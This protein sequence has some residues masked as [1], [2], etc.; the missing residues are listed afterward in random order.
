MKRIYQKGLRHF[1]NVFNFALL[2]SCGV[3]LSCGSFAVSKSC[4]V[5]EDYFGISPDTQ[6]NKETLD[7]LDDFNAVWLRATL[8]WSNIEPEEGK[9]Y[10]DHWDNYIAQAEAAKKKVVFVLAYDNPWL[11]SDHKEHRDMTDREIPYF[12]KYVEQV[13]SRYRTRAVYEIWNEPNWIFWYGSDKHFFALSAAT[14]KKIRE[15]EPGAVI[16]AGSTSRVSKSFTRGMFKSGAMEHTDGFSVH[17]YATSP[18]GEVM[19]IDKL[20]KIL[21]EFD[22][23]KPIWITETGYT[24]GPIGFCTIKQYPEYIV[25]TLSGMA[26][27]AGS[28]RNLIWYQLKDRY[29][30]GEAPDPLNPFHYFGLVY[31]NKTYKPGA[32]AFMLTA[33]YLAGAEYRP[34]LPVMEGVGWGITSLYFVKPDG[35]STLILWKNSEGKQK[36]RLTVPEAEG[37]SRHN[38]L[39]REIVPLPADTVLEINKEPAFITWKGGGHP[40]L[41]KK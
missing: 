11:Y 33:E 39:N 15:I 10:F 20:Q 4:L 30:P 1:Q 40:R 37:L 13:V 38:I 28:V 32:E 6:L 29:N 14:A 36:L 23:D 2:V 5:P 21:E 35:T 24:T 26:A 19:Q 7:L 17:P 31:P 18:L 3:F 27:R 12:L 34:E 22:Y 9:W 25:K 41:A 8:R 16:L